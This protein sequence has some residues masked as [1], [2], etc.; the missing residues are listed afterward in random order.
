MLVPETA[1]LTD[2]ELEA[3]WTHWS[4]NSTSFP[5]ITLTGFIDLWGG[6]GSQANALAS[7]ATALAWRD[8]LFILRTDAVSSSATFPPDAIEFLGT[9]QG[10]ITKRREIGQVSLQSYIRNRA[11]RLIL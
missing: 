10:Q 11:N 1:P 2:A 7:D 9:F 8:T 6:E 3:F 4:N 5:G